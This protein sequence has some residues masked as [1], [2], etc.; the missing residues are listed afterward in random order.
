M[1][2][3][4]GV[5]LLVGLFVLSI[6]GSA[7]AIRKPPYPVPNPPYKVQPNKY[8]FGV[9]LGWVGES[10]FGKRAQDGY[11]Y[12]IGEYW[13][14]DFIEACAFF[15]PARHIEIMGTFIKSGVDAIFATPVDTVSLAEPALEAWR[16]GIPVFTSDSY[17]F[18]AHLVAS[19]F[20]D[21]FDI[22]AD[23]AKFFHKLLPEGGNIVIM[24]I[25]SNEMWGIRDEGFRYGIRKYPNLKVVFDKAVD[26]V[27][28][29]SYLS[30]MENCLAANPERNS[31][32]GVWCLA[33]TQAAETYQA[34]LASGRGNEMFFT[35]CDGDSYAIDLIRAS[36]GKSGFTMSQGQSPFGMAFHVVE[37]AMKHFGREGQ[38]P[39]VIISNTWRLTKDN[40]P[41]AN[42]KEISISEGQYGYDEP[43]YAAKFGELKN[44]LKNWAE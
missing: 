15:K 19:V 5:L 6:A 7:L 39:R 20:S 21:N 30:A 25:I 35:G 1:S 40:I 10:E 18:D 32:Q 2:K 13:K 43:W 27:S 29:E 38:V 4:L 24:S 14:Q 37:L 11:R 23:G 16:Q 9:A 12:A 26:M 41:P 31:I 36:D 42:V 44:P 34:A 28:G 17:I 8:K 22:G 33:D 3:K